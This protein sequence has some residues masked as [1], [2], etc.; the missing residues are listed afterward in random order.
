MRSEIKERV[1]TMAYN[2]ICI[3]AQDLVSWLPA[4]LGT[5]DIDQQIAMGTTIVNKM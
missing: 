4:A 1:N 5:D 2:D 3:A